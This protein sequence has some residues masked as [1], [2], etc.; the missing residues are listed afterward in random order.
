ME[1]VRNT[2]FVKLKSPFQRPRGDINSTI[3]GCLGLKFRGDMS[4]SCK[5]SYQ[6]V[7]G[8]GSNKIG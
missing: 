2:D 6:V 5:C 1:S 4:C 8:I 3:I 7:D